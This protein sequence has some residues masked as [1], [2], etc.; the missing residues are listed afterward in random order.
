M[1]PEVPAEVFL[2]SAVG[3]LVPLRMGAA[4]ALRQMRVSE[5]PF[6]VAGLMR[7][8][9]ASKFGHLGVWRHI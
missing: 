9:R 5:P 1:S 3:R 4:T 6:G 7:G 2:P 8:S